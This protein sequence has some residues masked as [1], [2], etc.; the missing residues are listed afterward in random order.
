ML[1]SKK[2]Q[3]KGSRLRSVLDSALRHTRST[4]EHIHITGQSHLYSHLLIL[5]IL[6][7]YLVQ[8][9]CDMR[10]QELKKKH[11]ESL[12]TTL[13]QHPDMMATA[14][15]SMSLVEIC[16][17]RSVWKIFFTV[18]E[19]WNSDISNF[20]V[21]SLSDIELLLDHLQSTWGDEDLPIFNMILYMKSRIT[22]W[23]ES[24]YTLAMITHSISKDSVDVVKVSSRILFCQE[25][26]LRCTRHVVEKLSTSEDNKIVVGY[27]IKGMFHIT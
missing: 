3:T 27:L 14:I 8:K 11:M 5:F 4:E 26:L 9:L 25:L 15:I 13:S 23:R 18:L 1:L 21:Q 22:L 20:A 17:K 10:S 2:S 19:L 6:F 16:S 24:N 7:I 12:Q